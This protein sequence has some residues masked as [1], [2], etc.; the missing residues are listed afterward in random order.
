[1]FEAGFAVKHRIPRTK[2]ARRMDFVKRAE[3]EVFT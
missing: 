2:E 3:K 1:M